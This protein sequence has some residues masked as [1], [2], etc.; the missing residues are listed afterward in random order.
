MLPALRLRTAE[1]EASV[2]DS[3]RDTGICVTPAGRRRLERIFKD[4]HEFVWRLLR[5]LGLDRERAADMTQQAFLVAA[6]RLDKIKPGSERAF[7]FGTALRLAKTAFRADRRLLCEG[8]MEAQMDGRSRVDDL[9]DHNRAIVLLDRILSTMSTDLVTVFVLFELEGL[10]A[11]EVARLVGIPVGTAT[12]RLRRARE[13]FR[14][15]LG[16]MRRPSAREERS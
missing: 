7:L 2:E 12:S 16:K 8:N 15:N 11:P 9:A 5:R 4:N 10:S 6:E 3:A 1:T 14:D 13:V